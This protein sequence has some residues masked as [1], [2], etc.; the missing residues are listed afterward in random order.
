VA[1]AAD[2]FAAA[3]RE[4]LADDLNAA[5]ALGH[6]AGLQRAANDFLD[7]AKE[8]SPVDRIA[9]IRRFRR[10]MA[11]AAGVLGVLEREPDEALGAIGAVGLRRI[12]LTPAEL[13]G[14]IDERAQ[15]RKA[16]DFAAADGVR[17]A[18]LERG[19][20]L[21]DTPGGTEWRVVRG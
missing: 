11:E 4:A 1:K 15:A 21:M 9:A 10:A 19:V 5:E 20:E 13:Q 17:Q 7:R 6:L 14:R 8:G 16:K 2:G 12:G 18:L 3:F